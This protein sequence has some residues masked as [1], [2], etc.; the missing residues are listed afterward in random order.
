[1]KHIN[2]KVNIKF[3]IK[4][5]IINSTHYLNW[6]RGL[7]VRLCYRMLETLDLTLGPQPS[8][9]TIMAALL[10]KMSLGAQYGCSQ[11][12]WKFVS[13]TPLCFS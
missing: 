12:V 11:R 3:L 2:I 1:M 10:L 13:T 9:G 6:D 5:V 4:Q 7:E 8:R